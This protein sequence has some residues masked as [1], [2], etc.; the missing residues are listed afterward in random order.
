MEHLIQLCI[1][2]KI[3]MYCGS[4]FMNYESI[5]DF[6]KKISSCVSLITPICLMTQLGWKT[7]FNGLVNEI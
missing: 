6:I 1:E 3:N 2:K 4:L 5:M 7:S